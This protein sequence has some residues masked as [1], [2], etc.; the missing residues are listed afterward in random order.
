MKSKKSAPPLRYVT[1]WQALTILGIGII[2]GLTVAAVIFG[3]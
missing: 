1:I 3:D 2:L